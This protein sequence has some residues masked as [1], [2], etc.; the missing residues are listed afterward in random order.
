MT[1]TAAEV[2]VVAAP[3]VTAGLTTDFTM[4]TLEVLARL[5][6]LTTPNLSQRQP[7]IQT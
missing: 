2:K 6:I 1:T 3:T 7:Q 5:G 4:T